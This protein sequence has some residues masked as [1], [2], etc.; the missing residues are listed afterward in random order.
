L[1]AISKTFGW[2]GPPHTGYAANE[3]DI[4][5]V[6]PVVTDVKKLGAKGDGVTDDTKAFKKAIANTP[7]GVINVPA[8]RYVITDQLVSE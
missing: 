7:A 6:I 3:R 8:G 5:S 2:Y 4:P 1:H